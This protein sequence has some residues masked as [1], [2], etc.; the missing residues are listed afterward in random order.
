MRA[1]EFMAVMYEDN[2]V[3]PNDDL[4]THLERLSQRIWDEEYLSLVVLDSLFVEE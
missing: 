4:I 3:G 2:D 1:T